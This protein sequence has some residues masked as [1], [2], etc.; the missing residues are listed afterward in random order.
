MNVAPM[1]FTPSINNDTF[2]G[3]A[4][5]GGGLLLVNKTPIIGYPLILW[6]AIVL[7]QNLTGKS[8]IGL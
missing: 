1:P 3:S 6:G 7:Y 4:L 2:M 8:V 5:L